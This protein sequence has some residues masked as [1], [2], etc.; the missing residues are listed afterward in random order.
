MKDSSS[1]SGRSTRPKAESW[2]CQTARNDP[3]QEDPEMV[4]NG[5]G[6]LVQGHRRESYGATHHDDCADHNGY[7]KRQLKTSVYDTYAMC[8]ALLCGFCTCTIVMEHGY[9]GAIRKDDPLRYWALAAHAVTVRLCTACALYSTLVFM[10]S[11]MYTKTAL[12]QPRFSVELYDEYSNSTATI[13]KAAF[14]VMIAAFV[15][16]MLSVALLFFYSFDDRTAVVG[17]LVILVVTIAMLT[18]VKTLID[19]ASAIFLDADE[20]KKKHAVSQGACADETSVTQPLT[21]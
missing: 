2:D 7:E 20:L 16:Y 14:Y 6:E 17:C 12:S 21:A 9:L 18:H 4:S 5:T 3:A 1:M 19:S 11:S 8:G 15:M 10:L 13:R